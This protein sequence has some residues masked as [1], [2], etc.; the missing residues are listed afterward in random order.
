MDSP[1][2]VLIV[3]PAYNEEKRISAPLLAYLAE[4]RKNS[5]LNTRFLIVLN[6]C[7]D[8]TRKV[9]EEIAA[10]R[11]E[12]SFIDYPQAIGKG[13]AVIAGL[14]TGINEDWA[15]FADA[16]GATSPASL[17]ALLNNHQDAAAIIGTRDMS[18]RPF[19]RRFIS[20]GFNFII[21]SLFKFPHRD[22]QCG[23]KFFRGSALKTILPEIN[24]FDMAFDVNLLLA[25]HTHRLKVA[26]FQVDWHDQEGTSI[27]FLRTPFVMFLS[28]LRL[29]IFK[30]NP[31]TFQKFSVA[32]IDII[33]RLINRR[34]RPLLP[35]S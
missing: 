35:I 6:G 25:L 2:T 19:S 29:K 30:S 11:P 31:G 24:T 21:R 12:V 14:R 3:I 1:T 15:G 32:V 27:N 7:R 22:T 33:Y 28:V 18:G 4:A 16:D 5:H 17:F 26:E 9:V 34:P 8:N 13:G 10:G 20:G 23:A